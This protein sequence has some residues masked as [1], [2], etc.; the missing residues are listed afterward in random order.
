M[1]QFMTHFRFCARNIIAGAV[2]AVAS[3]VATSGTVLADS[4]ERWLNESFN[5]E[6]SAAS[7]SEF[8]ETRRS[9]SNYRRSAS[10]LGGPRVDD[11]DAAPRQRRRRTAS[12][13]IR[14]ASLGRVELPERRPRKS[15]SGGGG[16]TW[17]A[18]SGCLN[19][20]V[21]SVLAE[22]ASRF[23]GVTVNSTCR[24]RSH[25][26]AVGG[27]SRSWH[28]SGDAADFRVHGN[29]GAA[30]AY[31]RG[32]GRIGGYKHYGGGLFHIDTGPSRSW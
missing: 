18:S 27:A 29:W 16:I 19:G 6:R 14:V 31:L 32:G 1:S 11:E 24:S 2:I 30:A 26:A 28:L 15:L 8:R 25:N 4:A 20:T 17:V 13:N 3:A 10:R 21:R 23:G 7:R 12:R 9:R 22:V 5:A